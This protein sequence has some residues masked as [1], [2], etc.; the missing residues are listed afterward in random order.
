ML[1]G[2]FT[3]ITVMSIIVCAV[4]LA[5]FVARI[6][7]KKAPKAA[8]YALFAVVAAAVASAVLL[9]DPFSAKLPET[10]Q[11]A[12]VPVTAYVSN[13]CIYMNV[14]SSYA[15]TGD[16]GFRYYVA[17]DSFVSVWR[18]TGAQNMIA[19]PEWKWQSFPY[20][21]E[22]WA[23]L[24]KPGGLSETERISELF[25]EILY[26]P[27]IAGKFILMLDRE[28]WLVELGGEDTGIW[29][30]YSL[31]P[32]DSMGSAQ[33]E[34]TPAVSS[35]F[36][37]FRFELGIDCSEFTAACSQG[38][39]TDF[40]AQKQTYSAGITLSGEGAFYWS[41]YDENGDAVSSAAIYFSIIRGDNTFYNGTLYIDS[42]VG[43]TGWIYTAAIVGEGLHLDHN[44]EAEGGIISAAQN[45]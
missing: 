8:L 15:A 29:R 2:A 41:P 17:E 5:V 12:L 28:L 9:M 10:E 11:R 36:P 37:G 38:R 27:L 16:S 22:E 30:K 3:Y 6:L 23:A 20:T 7:L 25:D 24:Y 35:R 18:E 34:H 43:N 40:D 4:I 32:E 33:W 42:D 26:Q 1:S 19:V 39:L 31:V 21:D 44:S 13:R 14:L 45:C